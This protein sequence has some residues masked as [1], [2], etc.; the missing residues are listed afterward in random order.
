MAGKARGKIHS[1]EFP[2]VRHDVESEI[3][4]AAPDEFDFH[5]AQLRVHADH[6][7]A[8]N[9][10]APAHGIFRFR[11][12]GGAAS[13][14]H[15]IVRREPVVIEKMFGVVDHAIARAEFAGEVRWKNFRGDDVGTD[16][17]DF[18]SQH[19]GGFGCVCAAGKNHFARRDSAF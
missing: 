8:E 12:K 15:A 7:A 19:G 10:G 11:E 16:G 14:K 5:P 6:A 4:S 2:R 3:E 9:L 13:E 17:N 18:L 1:V